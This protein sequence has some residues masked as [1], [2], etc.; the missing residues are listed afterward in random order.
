LRDK[1]IPL[2]ISVTSNVL[3]KTVRSLREHPV[4]KLFDA[5]VPLV[6]NTDDPALFGVTLLDEY[7]MLGREF[8]FGKPE[9]E[10]LAQNGFDHGFRT[11]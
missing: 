2:E 6:I 9:L 7:E 5:G 8:G 1:G 10:Q 3:T 11:R 4:R